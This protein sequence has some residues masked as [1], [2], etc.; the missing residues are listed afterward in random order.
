MSRFEARSEDTMELGAL[1]GAQLPL[2]LGTVAFLASLGT[3]ET[4]AKLHSKTEESHAKQD[5]DRQSE[6]QC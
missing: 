4:P 1:L 3:I 2:D 5:L 6:R